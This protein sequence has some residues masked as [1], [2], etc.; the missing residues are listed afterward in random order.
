MAWNSLDRC[1]GELYVQSYV[2]TNSLV[3]A[4]ENSQISSFPQDLVVIIIRCIIC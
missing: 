2:L 1:M 4:Y 3:R